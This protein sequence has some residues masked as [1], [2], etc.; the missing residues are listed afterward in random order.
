[1]KKFFYNISFFGVV[2]GGFSWGLIALGSFLGRELNIIARISMA[3]VLV[4]YFIY[5]MIGILTVVFVFL[6]RAE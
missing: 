2:L 6:S 1:M 3:N 5:S 4:E